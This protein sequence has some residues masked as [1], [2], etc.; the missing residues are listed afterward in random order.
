MA[1]CAFASLL[2]AIIFID[3]AKYGQIQIFPGA[4][5]AD[6][7]DFLDV[8]DR[9][10][11]QLNFTK[12]GH[13]PG[14]G[15]GGAKHWRVRDGGAGDGTTSKHRGGRFSRFSLAANSGTLGFVFVCSHAGGV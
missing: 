6:L 4:G 3:Y 12:G 5:R 14:A 8:P 13:V 9:L 10:E 11:T 2:D 1:L 15:W 7:C